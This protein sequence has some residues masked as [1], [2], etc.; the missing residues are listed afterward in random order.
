MLSY[1]IDSA[2]FSNP[3]FKFT[4]GSRFDSLYYAVV[5]HPITRFHFEKEGLP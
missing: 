4:Q 3:K 2:A 5:Y 1:R